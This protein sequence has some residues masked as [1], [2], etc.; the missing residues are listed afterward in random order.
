[1]NPETLDFVTLLLDHYQ[2][3]EGYLT[4]TAIHPTAD[5]PC[6]SRHIQTHPL[7]QRKLI[8]DLTALDRANQR[9]WGAYF[10]VALRST[11]LGRYQR[12]RK[13]QISALSAL[14]VDIDQPPDI[15]LPR[16]DLLPP[17]SVVLSSGA[18]IH[19]YW[20]THTDDLAL[21]DNKIKAIN[22]R[23]G[24][25]ASINLASSMRLAGSLNTKPGRN[26]RCTLLRCDPRLIYPI[27][28]FPSLLPEAPPTPRR[29]SGAQRSTINPAVNAAVLHALYERYQGRPKNPHSHW[30]KA[31]CPLGHQ[32][33]FPGSHFYYDDCAAAGNCFGRHGALPLKTL[34]PLLGIDFRELGGLYLSPGRSWTAP[35]GRSR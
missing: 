34:C 26:T 28:R 22:Q 8:A 6:P 32:H 16:L 2:G 3:Q 5:K 7:N 33:D 18:G 27:S 17:A 31:L 30:H 35:H 12:G 13:D 29:S 20:F 9:G 19:A 1:M 14:F 23:V 10:A 11:D 24:G 25:D 21:A 4:L 15:A